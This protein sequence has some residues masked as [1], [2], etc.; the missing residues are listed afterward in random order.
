MKIIQRTSIAFA[1]VATLTGSA[2]AATKTVA[3][4]VP[5]MTCPTC[6]IT[7]KKALNKLPGVSKIDI[8]LSKKQ[9]IV[10]FDDSKTSTQA[11]VA[12][13]TNAGYPS[14]PEASKQ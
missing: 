2:W 10:T 4:D 5:G 7:V 14:T 8:D 6:P 11:L 3:L 12:A 13:T 1:I 9:A